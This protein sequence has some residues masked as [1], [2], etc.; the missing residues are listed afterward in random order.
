MVVTTR[1]R[2]FPATVLPRSTGVTGAARRC[3]RPQP[4]TVEVG[5]EVLHVFERILK[6]KKGSAQNLLFL[7][8][9][10][11][12]PPSEDTWE[13]ASSFGNC[14][15]ALDHYVREHV[16]S[17]AATS[18]TACRRSGLSVTAAPPAPQ[19]RTQLPRAA[20]RVGAQ[21]RAQTPCEDPVPLRLVLAEMAQL[22]VSVQAQELEMAALREELARMQLSQQEP[23]VPDAEHCDPPLPTSDAHKLVVSGLAG[24]ARDCSQLTAAFTV[25]CRSTL[26]MHHSVPPFK[27]VSTFGARQGAPG[28]AVLRFSSAEDVRRVMAAKAKFLDASCPISIDRNRPRAEREARRVA[29]ALHTGPPSRRAS[30]LAAL[31]SYPRAARTAPPPTPFRLNPNAAAFVPSLRLPVAATAPASTATTT[32]A[33]DTPA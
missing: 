30:M 26:R 19:R 1:S 32:A 24:S 8:R 12:H 7:V 31:G 10:Q 27:V 9:W 28:G 4:A 22:R 33:A 25:F 15:T 20:P 18:R 2:A 14:Q 5:G 17:G 6:H 3:T 23:V 13:P 29:R 11:G 21:E 16:G